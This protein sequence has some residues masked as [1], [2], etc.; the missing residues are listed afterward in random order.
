MTAFVQTV[1]YVLEGPSLRNVRKVRK[2]AARVILEVF[3]LR[4]NIV[5]QKSPSGPFTLRKRIGFTGFDPVHWGGFPGAV[6]LD[7]MGRI[8]CRGGN[9]SCH[10][11]NF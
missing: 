5:Q 6:S 7:P 8:G 3:E 4:Y 11:L 1:R 9:P 2:H 10:A